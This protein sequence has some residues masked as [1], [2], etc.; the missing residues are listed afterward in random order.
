MCGRITQY[1][2]SEEIAA[3]FGAE[4]E[5]DDSAERYNVAPTQMVM[6][7]VEDGAKRVVTAQRWGLIP[8][9]ADDP[10]IGSR[11]INAR[12][13]TVAEKPSFR[14][15]FKR[16]R[17]IIPANGFYEWQKR[18]D[19]KVPHAIVRKDEKPLA[20]AGLWSS[21]RDPESGE[22]VRSFAIITTTANATLAPIHDRMPVILPDDAIDT[23]LDP[24]FQD[25]PA[26]QSLL[27]PYPDDLL[28]AYPVS[29]LV[30]DV[31]ND[32][33]QLVFPLE[34]VSAR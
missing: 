34:E 14:A 25:V 18:G 20:L 21:W 12:G 4:D 26:L 27:R 11:L 30:N 28:R 19:R 5:V 2:T 24:N 23:W 33:P 31:R 7:V 16:Q 10:K 1:L 15:S 29:R 17:C 3:L 6:I 8:P 32:G 22:Q 9:W 13:E